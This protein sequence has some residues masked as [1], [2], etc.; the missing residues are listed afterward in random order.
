MTATRPSTTTSTTMTTSRPSQPSTT[1]ASNVYQQHSTG[2]PQ[3]YQPRPAFPPIQTSQ[4]NT[5]FND[6]NGGYHH[7]YIFHNDERNNNNQATSYQLFSNQGGS[8]TMPTPA[9]HQQVTV[10]NE[11]YFI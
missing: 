9:V 11:K 5:H 7:Q 6:K 8:S 10:F 4:S 3:H 2:Y 1:S